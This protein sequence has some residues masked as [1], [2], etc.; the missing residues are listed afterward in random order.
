MQQSAFWVLPL[1]VLTQC[2]K[3]HSGGDAGPL[4][5]GLPCYSYSGW[6]AL[7]SPC[8]PRTVLHAPCP[9]A[10]QQAWLGAKLSAE[11][12]QQ[13]CSGKEPSHWVP[14]KRLP[15]THSGQRLANSCFLHYIFFFLHT[16]KIC[17]IPQI[18]S[19]QIPPPSLLPWNISFKKKKRR[20]RIANNASVTGKTETLVILKS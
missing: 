15:V 18:S 3:Y 9:L 14:R 17:P 20:R 16:L 5:A 6:A 2:G 19:S 4:R 13:G 12:S 8:I 11:P 7:A 1:G 10:C